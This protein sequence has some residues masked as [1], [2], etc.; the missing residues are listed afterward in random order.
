M[1]SGQYAE[2]FE[3]QDYDFIFE[4]S[5]QNWNDT[6]RLVNL[7]DDDPYYQLVEKT[8]ENN[9]EHTNKPMPSVY[10][11]YR[12]LTPEYNLATYKAYRSFYSKLYYKGLHLLTANS[13]AEQE[14]QKTSA[15]LVPQIKETRSS[16]FTARID[17]VGSGKVP[18]NFAFAIFPIVD[19]VPSFATPL[20]SIP[21]A[22][23]IPS[24]EADDYSC[25]TTAQGDEMEVM[26]VCR[27]VVGRPWIREHDAPE[28]TKAPWGYH[29]VIGV[30]GG[31]LNYPE[32]I[33]YDNDAIR[34]AFL[35]MYGSFEEDSE[36][37][38]EEDLEEGSEEGSE[39]EDSE[40]D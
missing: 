3:A 34:P 10:A 16:S 15:N 32:T 23:S 19:C 38:S 1:T 28:L 39:E 11:V 24:E 18:Q 14:W 33:V 5:G 12:I 17:F 22:R 35:V 2:Y 7:D 31:R 27:V 29:S 21:L 30:P 25:T 4:H 9:W 20:M 40:E 26:L 6:A 36:E 37:D 13:F 8:F